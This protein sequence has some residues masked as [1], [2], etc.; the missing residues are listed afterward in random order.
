MGPGCDDIEGCALVCDQLP[1]CCI[2][3]FDWDA[4]CAAAAL[5]TFG[6]P[7]PGCGVPGT[8]DCFDIHGTIFCDDTCGGD[9]PC[10]GCCDLVCA[11]D[12]F[13]CVTSWDGPCV[14]EA[15]ELCGC[16]VEDTPPNNDCIDAIEVF[17]NYPIDVSTT[18]GMLAKS[19]IPYRQFRTGKMLES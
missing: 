12:P 1:F 11:L 19:G 17:V 8:L 16:A 15:M 10:F 18:C 7:D 14:G 5:D 3:G 13:C 9:D 2:P 4:G 6:T